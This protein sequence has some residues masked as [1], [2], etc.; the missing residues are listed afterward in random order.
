MSSGKKPF[1]ASIL[2]F[3]LKKHIK[4]IAHS[5]DHNNKRIELR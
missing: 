3:E 2:A 5:S 1:P 4:W